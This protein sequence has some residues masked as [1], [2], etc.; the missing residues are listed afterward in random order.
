[1]STQTTASRRSSNCGSSSISCRSTPASQTSRTSMRSPPPI[2][3][4]EAHPGRRASDDALAQAYHRMGRV[5]ALAKCRPLKISALT[6]SRRRIGVHPASVVP[7]LICRMHRRRRPI[8]LVE[9]HPDSP[10]LSCKHGPRSRQ[11][12]RDHCAEGTPSMI[13]TDGMAST[14]EAVGV[15]L[16]VIAAVQAGPDDQCF[17]CMSSVTAVLE[18]RPS[19]R[20]GGFPTSRATR[21][22]LP[23]G[24]LVVRDRFDPIHDPV[25]EPWTP[26]GILC[27]PGRIV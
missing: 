13:H 26:I 6:D 20:A 3:S 7:L 17:A 27:I 14:S 25:A 11:S 15:T 10:H 12:G 23:Q 1:M 9:I 19:P 8:L 16:P 4:S 21:S 24:L 5:V 2:P 22:G 18:E